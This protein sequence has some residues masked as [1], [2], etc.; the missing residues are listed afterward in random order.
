MLVG[1][2]V[3]MKRKINRR[4]STQYKQEDKTQENHYLHTVS[5]YITAQMYPM[6]TVWHCFGLIC[7]LNGWLPFRSTRHTHFEHHHSWLSIIKQDTKYGGA[8][9]T[10]LKQSMYYKITL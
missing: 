1:G 4:I 3:I 9:S 5:M 7:V 10:T 2:D 8:L 6:Y